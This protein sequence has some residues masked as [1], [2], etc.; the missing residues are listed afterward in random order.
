MA[1]CFNAVLNIQLHHKEQIKNNIQVSCKWEDV[2]IDLKI[3]VIDRNKFQDCWKPDFPL[4]PS[5]TKDNGL[6]LV[7]HEGNENQTFVFSVLLEQMIFKVIEGMISHWTVWPKE[8]I[9]N[10]MAMLSQRR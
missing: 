1:Q 3:A 8:K 2:F 4:K 6:D 9:C 7:S 5:L 10:M